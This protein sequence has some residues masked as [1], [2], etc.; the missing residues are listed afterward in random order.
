MNWSNPTALTVFIFGVGLLVFAVS[1]GV[2]HL[3]GVTR[4]RGEHRLSSKALRWI[5]VLGV[6]CLVVSFLVGGRGVIAQ[7]TGNGTE[8]RTEAERST[9]AALP[10]T[11]TSQSTVSS[12]VA[13]SSVTSTAV[14]SQGGVPV[15][16]RPS[17]VP[18]GAGCDG[19][20]EIIVNDS[21]NS[22]VAPRVVALRANIQ[23]T[24]WASGPCGSLKP[25]YLTYVEYD[26]DVKATQKQDDCS[27]NEHGYFTFG[28]KAGHHYRYVFVV[29]NENGQRQEKT[30]E[31]SVQSSS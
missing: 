20:F 22:W 24:V 23:V 7:W 17:S 9:T 30:W 29:E 28:I 2:V 4:S 5:A 6:L 26:N 21:S 10:A 27:N 15:S 18:R 13:P 25:C 16:N 14:S 19:P 11:S 3:V 31:F 8:P 1:G 12:S